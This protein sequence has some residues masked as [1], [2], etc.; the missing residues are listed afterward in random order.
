MKGYYMDS[1]QNNTDFSVKRTIDEFNGHCLMI[2]CNHNHA[3]RFNYLS[4]PVNTSTIHPPQLFYHL[5]LKSNDNDRG[6]V[7]LEGDFLND[8]VIQYLSKKKF[9]LIC[10]EAVTDIFSDQ[11]AAFQALKNAK[12]LLDDDG[13]CFIYFGGRDNPQQL[14]AVISEFTY[15]YSF[16]YGVSN[17]WSLLASNQPFE[18]ENI[19]NKNLYLNYMGNNVIKVKSNLII[20]Y[21]YYEPYLNR[22]LM[23]ANAADNALLQEMNPFTAKRVSKF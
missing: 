5:S 12:S 1:R 4:P 16:T 7:D 20:S 8:N 15:S 2:G 3:H 6:Q 18:L 13:I 19:I 10:F 11:H 21:N 14:Q 23:T 17:T 22:H 9:K